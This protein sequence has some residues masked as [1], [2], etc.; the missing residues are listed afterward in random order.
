MGGEFEKTTPSQS[1]PKSSGS[2]AAAVTGKVRMHLSGNEVHFHND[3]EGLKASVPFTEWYSFGSKINSND[4]VQFK[5]VD[6]VN[7]TIL[8][9]AI[10]WL[11]DEPSSIRVTPLPTVDPVGQTILAFVKDTIR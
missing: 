7:K 6:H 4:Y 9:I 10:D 11:G 1:T 3:A 5:Y 2:S 8:H